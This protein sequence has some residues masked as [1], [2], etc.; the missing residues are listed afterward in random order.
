[1]ARDPSDRDFV[2][3]PPDHDAIDPAVLGEGTGDA[4]APD[5]MP[6]P[7][8]HLGGDASGTD[9]HSH[10]ADEEELGPVDVQRWGAA[11]L[12]VALGLVVALCCWLA[13]SAPTA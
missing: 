5:Q 4:V 6:H 12:G 3:V 11:V 9:D 13:T 8:P 10:G 7:E 1:L 2:E